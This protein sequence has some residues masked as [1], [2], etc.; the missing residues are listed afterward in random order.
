MCAITFYVVAAPYCVLQLLPQLLL[1]VAMQLLL[2]RRA[3][4]SL[5]QT[6]RQPP[7]QQQQQQ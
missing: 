1:Q 3:P 2:Q 6:L 7:C 4:L 5:Q